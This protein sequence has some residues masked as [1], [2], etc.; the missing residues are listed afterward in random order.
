MEKGII[1]VFENSVAISYKVK[2]KFIIQ[3][4]D[5]IPRYLPTEKTHRKYLSTQ[6]LV[7]LMFI[8]ALSL[9]AKQE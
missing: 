1:T 2:H 7:M 8:A 9:I 4:C 6:R 3:P 5:P